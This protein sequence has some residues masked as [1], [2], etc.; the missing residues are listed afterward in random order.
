LTQLFSYLFLKLGPT[1]ANV[2]I[3]IF[4]AVLEHLKWTHTLAFGYGLSIWVN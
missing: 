4:S 2:L 1:I 3:G